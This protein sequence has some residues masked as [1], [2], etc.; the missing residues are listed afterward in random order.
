[1]AP[2]FNEK[3]IVFYYF[4]KDRLKKANTPPGFN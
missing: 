2:T 4:S 1:M 3:F